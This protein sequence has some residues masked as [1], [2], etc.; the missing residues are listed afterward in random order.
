M[1]CLSY[2]IQTMSRIAIGLI[3]DIPPIYAEYIAIDGYNLRMEGSSI[4]IVVVSE[5][6]H[7]YHTTSNTTNNTTNSTAAAAAAGTKY[8]VGL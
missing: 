1:R 2:K 4:A 7:H 3:A 5:T 8:K 6:D